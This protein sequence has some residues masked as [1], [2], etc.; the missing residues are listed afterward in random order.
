MSTSRKNF[1]RFALL[2]FIV[3]VGACQDNTVEEA[4]DDQRVQINDNPSQL[5]ERV[6]V[7]EYEETLSFD[8]VITT[9]ENGRLEETDS[10]EN[11]GYALVMRAEVSPPSFEDNTL[12]ASH[13]F[14]DEGL[15]FV[16]YNTEGPQFM[17]GFEVYD[18]SQADS[19]ELIYQVLVDGTDYSSIYYE[20]EKIYLAGAVANPEGLGVDSGAILEIFPY[21]LSEEDT[22]TV[23]DVASFVATDVKVSGDKIYVTSGSAGGLQVFDKNT[24][25]ELNS[26]E[27]EDARSVSFN[28]SQFV[29]MQGTPA[30]V[31]V[32]ETA[33]TTF[34]QIF[35]AGGAEIAESK[36][37]VHLTEDKVFVPTGREGL[38]TLDLS[39]GD[40]LQQL[41]LP[42]LPD[43]APELIVSNG[44]S[45]NG[46][47]VFIANGAAGLFVGSYQTDD[48]GIN[49][50]GSVNFGASANFV[51]SEDDVIFVATG[52]GGLKIL[53]IVT[54]NP[55]EGDYITIG[56]W[57][58]KGIP[59]YLCETN[60]ELSDEQKNLIEENFK[61][62]KNLIDRQPS[63]FESGV[64]TDLTIEEDTDLTVSFYSESAG[65]KNTLGYYVYD[66][67]N[68]PAT[69]S[70]IQNMTVLFP[71][72]S[73]KGKGGGLVQGDKIC[74]TNLKAGQVVG[75]FLVA[76]GW[77]NNQA[78]SGIYTHY[79]TIDLNVDRAEQHRQANL[80]LSTGENSPVILGFEDIK[81]PGGDK[82]YD[83]AVFLLEPSNLNSID[84]SKLVSIQ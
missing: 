21:P 84:Y 36:S 59:D 46:D 26:I 54:Y 66:Q 14:I 10:D 50:L 51:Q 60:T 25:E 69:A 56:D 75:F 5:H 76:Q 77:K 38:K 47:K 41:E 57:D 23:V 20:D 74:I 7:P 32:F 31:Q 58:D 71:N 33:T 13:V 4:T 8:E 64:V 78:T 63:Y 72:A 24:L 62:T 40:L 11:P 3:A 67:N 19:P 9:S 79:S 81:L 80:L 70:E 22:S 68:P 39:T 82:D 27:M 1:W 45:V 53:E 73:A 2:S 55:E 16:S 28:S 15:A 17:G 42:E 48:E 30:R 65:W 6:R 49:L 18:V 34:Q 43:I 29:V 35:T 44:V 12:K 37:I 52:T 61:P 83:D